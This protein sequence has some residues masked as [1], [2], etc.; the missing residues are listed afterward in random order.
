[1]RWRT[2]GLVF[3]N[4]QELAK[5]PTLTLKF[6]GFDSFN[7]VVHLKFLLRLRCV[8]RTLISQAQLAMRFAMEL[9]AG[10]VH[11][12][13]PTLFDEVVGPFGGIKDSGSGREGGRWS[14]EE[15]TELK[16]VTIQM[17]KR[18]YPF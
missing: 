2:C 10:M 12:N 14:I 5:L 9:E 17:G 3:Q 16:W 8:A 15:M 6:G 18:A 4:Y 1:M 7:L 13:G 11:L